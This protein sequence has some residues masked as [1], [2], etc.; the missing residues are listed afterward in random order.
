MSY[1]V[2]IGCP[3]KCQC[4]SMLIKSNFQLPTIRDHMSKGI[5]RFQSSLFGIKSN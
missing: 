1:G 5:E 3:E 2:C 4:R